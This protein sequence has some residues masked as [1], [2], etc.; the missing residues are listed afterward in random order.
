MKVFYEVF[1]KIFWIEFTLD[2][3]RLNSEIFS[4][5]FFNFFGAKNLRI[6]SLF[7]SDGT[8]LFRTFLQLEYNEENLAFYLA[9]EK[10]K[11]LDPTGHRKIVAKAQ[12]IYDEFIRVEAPREVNLDSI[13]RATTVNNLASPNRHCFDHAQRRV[14]HVLEKD[15]Y[16]RFLKFDLYT[17]LLPAVS[18]PAAVDVPAIPLATN[19]VVAV[20]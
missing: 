13:T 18:G 6:L 3:S 10:F 9:C 5:D 17:Q 11:R 12:K 4:I 7:L 19:A 20:V 14:R 8:A 2:F 15:V 1:Y 16:P